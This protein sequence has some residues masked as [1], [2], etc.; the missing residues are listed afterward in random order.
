MQMHAAG[1]VS[2]GDF[3]EKRGY[4]IF[5]W[6]MH[7]AVTATNLSVVGVTQREVTATET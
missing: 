5:G 2:K 1:T 6:R 7:G 4:C 3:T